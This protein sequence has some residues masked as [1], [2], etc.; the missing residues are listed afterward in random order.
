MEWNL[1]IDDTPTIN[2]VMNNI[3]V[4]GVGQET[5]IPMA[6]SMDLLQYIKGQGIENL[7]NLALA[8]GGRNGSS[9]RDVY[10]RQVLF[11]AMPMFLYFLI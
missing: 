7:V 11:R 8:I 6:I 10:K 9:S 5:T 2:G 3:T 1:Y 4:P